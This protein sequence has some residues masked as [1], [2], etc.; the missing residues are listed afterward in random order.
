MQ[1]DKRI[2]ESKNKGFT[3]VELLIAII[4]AAILSTAVFL[5]FRSQQNS[6]VVQDEVVKL[7]QNLRVAMSFLSRDVMMTGCYTSL[8][9]RR[10]DVNINGTLT[11]TNLLISGTTTPPSLTLFNIQEPFKTLTATEYSGTSIYVKLDAGHGFN[12]N[13]YGLLIKKDMNR[14]ELFQVQS[15]ATDGINLDDDSPLIDTYNENDFIAHL[16]INS[17]S[18]DTTDPKRPLLRR[19]N[20]ALAEYINAMQFRYILADNSIVT[21]INLDNQRDVRAVEITLSGQIQVP[22]E[23]LK[24]RSLV[25]RI[26]VR[27]FGLNS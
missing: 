16:D 19:G 13:D 21:S 22:G 3:L 20:Q 24:T 25:S 6:Y 17:Y 1:P 11:E 15:L 26:K 9:T 10:Y 2:H 14:A 23:G 18:L 4:L 7:Q 12:S 5:T 8:S 27:N